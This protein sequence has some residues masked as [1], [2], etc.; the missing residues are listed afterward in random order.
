[1]TVRTGISF[2]KAKK[3]EAYNFMYLKAFVM[4]SPPNSRV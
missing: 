4:Y 1:V 3:P 2:E